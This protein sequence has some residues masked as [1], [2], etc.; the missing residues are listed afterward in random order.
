MDR[1]NIA[2]SCFAGGLT[3][4][5][6]AL[7]GFGT[8]GAWII[9]PAILMG[10]LAAF[11]GY[12]PKE[13]WNTTVG[14]WLKT[15]ARVPMS[16]QSV[17][18]IGRKIGGTIWNFAGFIILLIR[19]PFVLT[20]MIVKG[21]YR[22]PFLALY[23]GLN[24][25]MITVGLA[26]VVPWVTEGHPNE[27]VFWACCTVFF[28]IVGAIWLASNAVRD[29]K[30]TLKWLDPSYAHKCLF[31]ESLYREWD[32]Y[33]KAYFPTDGAFAL[34]SMKLSWSEFFRQ[35]P[36]I[37]L[38][39]AA[40]PWRWAFL[41]IKMIGGFLDL[42][43]ILI[44]LT[45]LLALFV[46]IGYLKLTHSSRRIICMIDGP[47]GGLIGLSILFGIH[48]MSAFTLPWWQLGLVAIGSGLL[49][50]TIGILNDAFVKER[51]LPRLESDFEKYL[52]NNTV[53]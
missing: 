30:N 47:L 2:T 51:L 35:M 6:T 44:Q 22:R 13:V 42:I 17:R 41:L 19:F 15:K 37:L 14:A 20:R 12:K 29:I 7:I 9:I 32:P 36:Y 16:V 23:L 11:F 39:V 53:N 28:A 34:V 21:T 10:A 50:A 48:G 38:G 8:L 18:T 3:T 26:I 4:V 1:T 5:L 46:F 52:E 40:T 43:R 27:Y 33:L 25:L 49:S 31:N 45:G 24:V